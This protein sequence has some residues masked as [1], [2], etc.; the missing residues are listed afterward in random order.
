MLGQEITFNASALDYYDQQSKAAQFLITGTSHL[1]YKISNDSKC[2]WAYNK[3]AQITNVQILVS[4]F[5]FVYNIYTCS[6]NCSYFL[7]D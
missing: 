7:N 1:D 5:V 2:D 3:T 4:L 6:V